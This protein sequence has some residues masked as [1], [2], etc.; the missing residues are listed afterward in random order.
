M[1]RDRKTP[2]GDIEVALGKTVS[3]LRRS[4]GVGQEVFAW[5]AGINRTYITDIELGRRSVGIGV[6][7]KITKTLNISLVEFMVH[8]TDEL[9]KVKD[10][11]A[12]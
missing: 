10:S 7:E 12:L 5:K 9:E 11:K 8:L 3:R 1:K 4:Q 6:I 2:A